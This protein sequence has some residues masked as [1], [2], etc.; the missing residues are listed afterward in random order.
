MSL[1]GG[2]NRDQQDFQVTVAAGLETTL[3]IAGEFLNVIQCNLADFL[4]SWDSDP[5]TYAEKGTKRRLS[6]GEHFRSITIDNSGNA[7]ALT[8]RIVV[9][10]GDY[11]SAVE[12][13]GALSI[14]GD[15]SIAKDTGL[16]S[17]SDVTLVAATRATI[18]AANASRR[19]IIVQSLASNTGN[20]RVG[21]NTCTD[22]AP[23]KGNELQPGQSI[24]IKTTAAV[25]AFSTAGGQVLS[26]NEVTS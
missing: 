14:T 13:A 22:V 24:T 8:V 1:Q 6:P 5:R 11:D 21:D 9:G 19:A 4:L 17:D 25:Y 3:N 23:G 20:V 7:S 2:A 18:K 16:A 26:I 10:F 12:V 15:V